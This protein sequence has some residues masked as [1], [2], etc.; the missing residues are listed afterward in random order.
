MDCA[1]KMCLPMLKKHLAGIQGPT[2]G[3]DPNANPDGLKRGKQ[4]MNIAEEPHEKGTG[5]RRALLIGCNYRG[6]KAELRGCINDVVNLKE[7]LISTFKWSE[8][9]ITTM[10]DDDEGI[11]YPSKEN[12]LEQARRL[13]EGA[14]PGDYF[15]FS[16]SGHGGQQEDP[17]GHEEDG[18]NETLIP[19]DYQAAGMIPDNE[20]N[21]ILIQSLPAKSKLSIVFDACH[22]GSGADLSF[23]LTGQGWK[24]AINPFHV[25]A[26]VVMISGCM[27]QQTSADAMINGSATGALTNALTTVWGRSQDLPYID[28]LKQATAELDKGGYK[29]RPCL[30]SSQAFDLKRNFA[31]DMIMANKNE[32]LGRIERKKFEPQPNPAIMSFMQQI[33]VGN[34]SEVCKKGM[35]ML[36]K[37]MANQA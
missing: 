14:Q 7:M 12:V 36:Q 5:T 21:E 26:D 6:S 19:L 9:E 10:T 28:L 22:S 35:A 29:Q 31:L 27:D 13:V 8:S 18:M 11:M 34:L 37:F 1:M 4:A 30:T 32:K 24:E 16:Y 23:H 15:W 20:L 33:D 25:A 2:R 3:T 17:D